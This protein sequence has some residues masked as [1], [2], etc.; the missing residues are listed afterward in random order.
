M[1]KLIKTLLGKFFPGL[2][3]PSKLRL[4]KEEILKTADGSTQSLTAQG[5]RDIN[6][7][8]PVYYCPVNITVSTPIGVDGTVRFERL[9]DWHRL[10]D[11]DNDFYGNDKNDRVIFQSEVTHWTY[12]ENLDTTN[13]NPKTQRNER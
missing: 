8:K 13:I 12:T 7:E 5:W 3:G 10:S 1:M 4:H 6:K 2:S 11:G 9:E